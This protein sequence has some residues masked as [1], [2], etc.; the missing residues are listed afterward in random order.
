M[1]YV[2]VF[3]NKRK[4]KNRFWKL[5]PWFRFLLSGGETSSAATT[6]PRTGM[7]AG[8]GGRALTGTAGLTTGHGPH[9]TVGPRALAAQ[10]R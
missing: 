9:P 5:P 1:I 7:L 3:A 6:G 2:T 10:R 4:V 8:S